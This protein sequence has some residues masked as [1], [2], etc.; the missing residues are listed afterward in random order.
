MCGIAGLVAP[1]FDPSRLEETARDMGAALRHRG[2]DDAGVWINAATGVVLSHQRLSVV[3]LSAAGHQPM[4]SADGRHILVFNGE[5]YNHLALREELARQGKAPS[6]RG[7]SDSETLVT[8]IAAWGVTAAVERCAGQFAFAVWDRKECCLHLARD[9]MGE[10]PLYYGWAGGCFVFA[11]EL[12]A[13]KRVPDFDNGIDRDV[14]ALYFEFSQVPSPYSIYLGIYKLEAGCCL[15]ISAAGFA[16]PPATAPFAPMTAPGFSLAPYWTL[17]AAARAGRANPFT[18]EDEAIAALDQAL[19]EAVRLQMLA[20]VPVGA[21]LSGGIDSSTVVALMEAQ[22]SRP[23]RTFT[24]G[25]EDASYDERKTARAVAKH[26]GTEHRD[27]V[28]SASEAQAVIPHLAGIYCEPFADSSQVA[29]YLVAR[30]AAD[31]VT[32]ALSGDGGDELFGGYNRHVWA[33]RIAGHLARLPAGPRQFAGRLLRAIPKRGYD[34]AGGW[35]GVN[36]LEEKV[37]KL[38]ERM[39]VADDPA[40]LYASLVREWPGGLVSGA[41]PLPTRLD[42][43]RW[44]QND[45][46]MAEAM[47]AWDALTYLP[48]DILHKVDRATMA[49]SLEGRMPLLDHRVVELAWRVPLSMKIRQGRGKWLLRQ[50][51]NKYVPEHLVAGPK[52][53]FALPIGQWLRGPLRDWAEALIERSRLQSG[54]Y[55]DVELVQRCWAEHLGGQRDWTARLWSVLMF[56]AWLE[57]E[58]GA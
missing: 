9:R 51:L 26:L 24:I 1:G 32:V 14:L 43:C 10:K 56:Q 22:S 44:P 41:K 17:E 2:P 7:H 34:W 54:G 52:S 28:L 33:P 13:L 37:A 3:D 30:M 21:F 53:G 16:S 31:E 58:Q 19:H 8:C 18:N 25:F 12:K 42:S 35:L 11:S 4:V 47:M 50:V 38:A 36:R 20:D 45:H 23:V 27:M 48:D 29:T 39:D 40:A 49:V 46:G 15:S 5:I 6:W 57:R 55:L